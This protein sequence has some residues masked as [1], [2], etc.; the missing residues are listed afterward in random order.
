MN[1]FA[2]PENQQIFQKGNPI[3]SGKKQHN[4]KGNRSQQI[5][6]KDE[7][8]H[9]FFGQFFVADDFGIVFVEISCPEADQNIDHVNQVDNGEKNHENVTDFVE[10]K[11]A[12]DCWENG[13]IDEG[14]AKY[15]NAP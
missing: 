7:A 13:S 15:E 9:V 6:K 11:K 4:P 8:F 3:V 1:E 5:E 10:V 14:A 2:K 12:D